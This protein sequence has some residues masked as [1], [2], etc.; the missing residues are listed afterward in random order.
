MGSTREEQRRET[1]ARVLATASDLFRTSGYT[2]TT[3]RDIAAAA[4]VSAGT[5]M[6]VGDKNALLVASFDQRIKEIH[7][8]RAGNAAPVADNVAEQI[9]ALFE[10]FAELFTAD[11]GL[12]RIYGSV[13]VAGDTESSTFTELASAL[14]SEIEVVLRSAD[15]RDA[16]PLS[17]SIYFAYIGRLF[18]WPPD[19]DQDVDQLKRSLKRIVAAIYQ[20]KESEA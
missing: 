1:E 16:R 10:P 12:A 5:V 19:D 13:L 8:T 3:V 18:T 17:E 11:P 15:A 6:S 7:L 2:V 4:G 9:A 20:E 14:I